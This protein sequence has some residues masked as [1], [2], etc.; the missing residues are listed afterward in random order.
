MTQFIGELFSKIFNGNVVLA[1]IFVSMIPIMELK[2][3]IPFGM[4]VAFWGDK[5]LKRWSAFGWAFLGC[6]IVTII[7]YF[8]FTPLMNWFRKTKMFKGLANFIDNKVNSQ[9]QK[10]EK[11]EESSNEQVDVKKQRKIKLIK[12]FSVLL[13]VA[14]PLPLTGVW[15]GTCLAV[16]LQLNF[17][18]TLLA[19]SI[20][21]M[22]AGIIISTICVIFPQFTHILIYL[23][24]GLVVVLAVGKLI[25]NLI[26]KKSKQQVD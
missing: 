25:Y 10:I 23:F 18:E 14:I 3:G 7:V 20:G 6:F 22:I 16:V 4:S 17:G 21:N 12:I 15:M 19:V 13:F 11:V 1:T 26:R 5:A 8:I 24:I 9:K 2:G